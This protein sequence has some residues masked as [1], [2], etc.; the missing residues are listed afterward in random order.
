[1]VK[2]WLKHGESNMDKALMNMDKAHIK[3][4]SSMDKAWIKRG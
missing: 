4:G 2:A 3:H 1:M